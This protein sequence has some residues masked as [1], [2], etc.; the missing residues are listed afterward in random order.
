MTVFISDKDMAK[1]SNIS[2]RVSWSISVILKSFKK[3]AVVYFQVQKLQASHL[4]K[5]N[6]CFGTCAS[7]PWNDT[8]CREKVQ[9]ISLRYMLWLIFYLRWF[10]FFLCFNFISI[11]KN[12]RKTKIT[13]DK[14][15][16][17]N[18]YVRFLQVRSA[19]Y[20]NTHVH[21]WEIARIIFIRKSRM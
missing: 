13:W 6:A 17:Y 19:L 20:A 8:K 21:T 15:I 18:I 7:Y 3:L 5:K 16:N 9:F 14:K 1:L 11:T 12:K 2:A 4:R 10:S